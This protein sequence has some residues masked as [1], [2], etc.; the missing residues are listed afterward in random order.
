[1]PGNEGDDAVR[2]ELSFGDL[3]IFNDYPKSFQTSL[4]L[5]VSTVAK[6]FVLSIFAVAQG[7]LLGFRH[8]KRHW[9]KVSP[10]M[11]AITVGLVC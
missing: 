11:G 3:G 9:G 4:Q 6:G 2:S 8:F 5:G 10:C 1:M 7:Y